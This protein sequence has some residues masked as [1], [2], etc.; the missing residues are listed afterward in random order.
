MPLLPGIT[1]GREKPDAQDEPPQPLMNSTQMPPTQIQP[2][3]PVNMPPGGP[4]PGTMPPPLPGAGT[5]IVISSRN[6][7]ERNQHMFN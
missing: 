2:L 5:S 3:Q 6:V 4:P 1:L 7:M